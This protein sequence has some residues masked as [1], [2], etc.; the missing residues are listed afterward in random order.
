[1][2]QTFL[3]LAYLSIA[4]L[5]MT[6]A[7]YAIS[8]SYLGR[9]IR[10]SKWLIEKRKKKL[11]KELGEIQKSANIVDAMKQKLKEHTVEEKMLSRHLFLLSLKGAVLIPSVC[12]LAVLLL[13]GLAINFPLP[14]YNLYLTFGASSVVL[15]SGFL[16]FLLTLYTI[17]WAASRIPLP[18]FEVT[19]ESG[20]TKETFHS[21]EEKELNFWLKNL[22]ESMGED[23]DMFF[24]FPP[25]F[26]VQTECREVVTQ[27]PIGD[28]P[29]C[30]AVIIR[31]EKMHVDQFFLYNIDGLTMPENKGTY[32]VH[33][34]I[35]EKNTGVSE[36]KLT[37]EIVG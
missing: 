30:N 18:V 35:H 34:R 11:Q 28:F 31:E 5:S 15:V 19:F 32:I 20:L 21:K 29:N 17:E 7:A 24:F 10:R 36:F 37:F 23:L 16:Y 6:I 8:V 14:D 12:F 3:I 33:V 25:E 27:R 13:V 2:L 9:E 26:G 4:L 22:G 1:M